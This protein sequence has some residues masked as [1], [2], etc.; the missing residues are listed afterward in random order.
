MANKL[1]KIALFLTSYIPLMIII[2]IQCNFKP[3]YLN[4]IIATLA[5]FSILIVALFFIFSRK[6]SA[7]DLP[8]TSVA[9][10]DADALGYIVTYLV[11]YLG[12]EL[13]D[14]RNLI[15]VAI[16]ILTLMAIYVNS[17]MIFVNP[18][19]NLMGYHIFEITDNEENFYLLLSRR[20]RIQDG[21]EIKV[22]RLG[23]A[24]VMEK[25]YGGQTDI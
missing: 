14:T 10:K 7:V 13:A 21:E 16:V 9:N 4:V 19:V 22:A 24:V 15:S 20:R 5:G 8:V 12:M 23:G 6:I 25:C 18:V 17:N 2:S 11:P 3:L 1:S